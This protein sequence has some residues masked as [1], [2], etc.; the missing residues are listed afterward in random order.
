MKPKYQL[1]ADSLR[2]KIISTEYPVGGV[3]PT[4]LQ[5]QE[6]Y[7]ASRYT[8]RQAVSVLVAEG[9]LR[10]E[11]GSGTYVNELVSVSE[12]SPKK[13]IGVIT[14]YISDYIFPTIIRG[15]EKELKAEGYSLLLSSTNNDYFQEKECLDRMIEFGVDGLIVEPTKSNQY[16]PNLATYVTLREHNIPIVMIN[17]T[18]EEL[19]TPSIHVDDV[20]TGYLA[21]KE[22]IDNNHQQLL[23]ITKI[24]DL[25]G[26]YRMKGFIKACEENEIKLSSNSIITYT[27]ETEEAIYDKVIAHLEVFSNIT[28]ILCYNDK[29]AK[30]L[31]GKL[32][33]VG[34]KVPEDFSIVGNDDST[35]SQMGEVSLTTTVHPKEEMGVDAAKW[36]VNTIKNGTFEKDILYPPKLIRRNSVKKLN[37][38]K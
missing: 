3:I 26:K 7:H 22:L 37:P 4:E 32:S 31:I 35:L 18:Y 24:D 17:A 6:E 28:G 21:T 27:T 1:I 15:I 34:Y 11:K 5:L 38:V 20:E 36:I 19:N 33:A 16:N 8:V 2:D 9:Y 10:K 14:T 29:I 13:T 25:Q 12:A 23:L 30:T